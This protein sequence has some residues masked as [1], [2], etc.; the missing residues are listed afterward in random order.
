MKNNLISISGKINSGKDTVAAI[1]QILSKAPHLNNKGVLKA[2]ND[3]KSLNNVYN[4]KKF[5]D[6][7]KDMVCLL[8]GCTREQLEDRDFKEK[9]LGKEWWVWKSYYDNTLFTYTGQTMDIKYWELIK[10]TPRKLLQLIG[11]ECGRNILHPNIWVNALFSEYRPIDL[12][13]NI[14]N[15]DVLD[16]SSATFPNWIISDMRFPNELQAVKDRDGL[17][18]RVNRDIDCSLCFGKGCTHCYEGKVENQG[19][20]ESETAL[21]DAEFDI[22]INN[23]GTL[24]DLIT[25]VRNLQIV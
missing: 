19:Q 22:I 24:D 8:L 20:H 7:L 25:K 14:S 10:L 12:H 15:K 23:N 6:R 18:I 2:L 16:Y 4:I 17:T 1:L 21:D 5:A 13:N 11:T 3:V 9:E